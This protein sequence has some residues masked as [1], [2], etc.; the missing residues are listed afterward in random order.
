MLT[1]LHL[2][3]NNIICAGDFNLLFNIKLESYGG[4][5]VFKKRSVRKIF[6]LKETYFLTDIWRIKS[7]KAKQYTFRQKRAPGFLQ[8]RLFFFIYN[9]IQ[10]FILDIDIIPVISFDHLLI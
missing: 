9:N 6:E 10:E 2:T 4:N 7:P 8:S 5:P 3:Q 1:R